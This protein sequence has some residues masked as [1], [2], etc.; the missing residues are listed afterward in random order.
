M[1]C[2]GSLPWL[3]PSSCVVAPDVILRATE[4]PH[5]SPNYAPKYPQSSPKLSCRPLLEVPNG[6]E[7]R[8]FGLP[9]P[10]TRGGGAQRQ[11]V[12]RGYMG[13]Q[14]E[15]TPQITPKYPQN[16][17]KI[18]PKIPPKCTQIPSPTPPRGPNPP[19]N[20]FFWTPRPQNREGGCPKTVGI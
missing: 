10:K 15:N 7:T 11:W 1:P 14:P 8:F 18:P 16:A 20:T 2:W 19:Q 4:L 13:T 5:L 9:D 17:H 3:G 12:Y 6:P